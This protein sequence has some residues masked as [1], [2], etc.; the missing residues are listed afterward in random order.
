MRGLLRELK[1]RRVWGALAAYPAAAFLL[2]E[3]VDYFVDN[4]DLDAKLIRLSLI[5]VIGGLPIALLWNWHHGRPG[6]QSVGRKEVL[7]YVALAALTLVAAGW[8]WAAVPTSVASRAAAPSAAAVKSIA[9]LPFQN[10]RDDVDIQFLCDGIAEDVINWLAA[11]PGVRV[12]ARSSAFALRDLSERPDEV[13]QRL[14]VESVLTGRLERHGDDVVV[15]A[16]LV[17]ARDNHRIWGDRFA[18]PA[19]KALELEKAIASAIVEPLRL[20]LSNAPAAHMDRR[21]TDNTEAYQQYLQGRFLSQTP[22]SGDSNQGLEQLRE[23]TR[24][25]PGFALAYAGIADALIQQAFF[26]AAPSS[27]IVG[28]ARTAAQSAIALGPDLPEGYAAL[29]SVR[30]FFDFDWQG[31]DEAFKQAIALGPT[32]AVAYVRYADLLMA[33]L[34]FEEAQSTAHKALEIDPI[35][36]S[37]LHAVGITKFWGGDF[38]GAAEAFEDWARI[39][40]DHTWSHVKHGLALA[41]SGKCDEALAVAETAEELSRGWGS[42]FMQAW[43]AW[44]YHLC[45]REELFNRAVNRIQRGIE[46]NR[47]EDP[48]AVVFVYSAIGDESKTLDWMEKMVDQRSSTA[49]FLQIFKQPYLRSVVPA[50]LQKNPRYLELLRRMNFPG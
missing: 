29:G 34:R 13:G 14:N 9:V 48:V 38:E 31:A 46:D 1:E 16:A 22:T 2:L 25:D 15:N 21:G 42:A 44:L 7:S 27:Q 50:T 43:L 19:T 24:L 20:K 45:D 17:D 30:F 11:V 47:I 5:I 18:R 37:A 39:H 33:L 8:Y 3:A 36:A 12:I 23:A 32:S 49:A 28:E 41:F 40:P 6:R 10:V 4:F 35:D 26:S